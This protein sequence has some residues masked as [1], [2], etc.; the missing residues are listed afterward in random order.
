MSSDQRRPRLFWQHQQRDC[1]GPKFLRAK[2]GSIVCVIFVSTTSGILEK[3]A[4]TLKLW[5]STPEILFQTASNLHLSILAPKIC[6]RTREKAVTKRKRAARWARN[7]EKVVSSSGWQLAVTHCSRGL[8][9]RNK[10]GGKLIRKGNTR[11]LLNVSQK[12]M[13]KRS[14]NKLSKFTVPKIV[15]WKSTLAYFVLH[16]F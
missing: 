4:T 16:K 5:S 14:P 13:K 3:N 2:V 6:K 10:V 15:S 12:L 1:F 7:E 11:V 8:F 9:D